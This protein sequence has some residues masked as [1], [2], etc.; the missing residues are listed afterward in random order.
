MRRGAYGALDAKR[1]LAFR[2]ST[3]ALFG[4]AALS[5]SGIAA[6]SDERSPG[7]PEASGLSRRR[8]TPLP[9]PPSGSPPETPLNERGCEALSMTS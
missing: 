3:V 7:P 4:G 6:G 1:T 8:R 5:F 9:A 2:R